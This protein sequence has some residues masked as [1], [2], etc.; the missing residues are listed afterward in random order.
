M[1][2]APKIDWAIL[3]EAVDFYREK[4]FQYIETPWMVS[5]EV[6]RITCPD[7][8]YHDVIVQN[9]MTLV[10]SA[11]QGFLQL[12]IDGKLTGTS[13]VS[14]GPCFR[15]RDAR[16]NQDGLHFPSFMKVELYIRCSTEVDALVSARW[17]VDVAREFMGHSTKVVDYD[18]SW[19]LE[20]NGVEVG[21][22]GAR[23]HGDII[24]AYGTGVALPRYTQAVMN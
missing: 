24:W 1:V 4:G 19:D 3:S 23:K 20:L 18:D 7:E 6:S 8:A 12:E 5:P 16:E 13:Y 11:E 22:Y 2:N 10:A 15:I 9:G 14:C 17:L 21:S